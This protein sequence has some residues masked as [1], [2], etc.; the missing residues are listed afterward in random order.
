MFSAGAFCLL[1]SV[2]GSCHICEG[3]DC[4]PQIA[5]EFLISKTCPVTLLKQGLRR[6]S[7]EDAVTRVRP[8]AIRLVSSQKRRS[9]GREAEINRG[10]SEVK[11]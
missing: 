11:T 3:L 7:R 8:K 4:G 10:E 9:F 5:V 1:I 2:R 6:G